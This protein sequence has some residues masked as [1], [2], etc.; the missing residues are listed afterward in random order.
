MGTNCSGRGTPE[1]KGLMM[2][3]SGGII[4]FSNGYGGGSRSV[5]GGGG[6]KAGGRPESRFRGGRSEILGGPRLLIRFLIGLGIPVP[7]GTLPFKYLTKPEMNSLRSGWPGP[8]LLSL[9]LGAIS[10]PADRAG[11]WGSRGR[12]RPLGAPTASPTRPRLLCAVSYE[13]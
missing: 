12:P 6:C 3:F 7:M 11:V 5:G 1:I 8:F 2:C 4:G 13:T 9:A 10:V